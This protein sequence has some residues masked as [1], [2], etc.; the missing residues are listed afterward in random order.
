MNNIRFVIGLGILL[1]SLLILKFAI[2]PFAPENL[3]LPLAGALGVIATG[4]VWGVILWL[5]IRLVRGGGRAPDVQRFIFYTAV[6][7]SIAYLFLQAGLL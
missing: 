7:V 1:I 6:A 5:P 2:E 3:L 4:L